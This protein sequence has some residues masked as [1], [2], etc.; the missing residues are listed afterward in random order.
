VSE[1]DRNRGAELRAEQIRWKGRSR[2]MSRASL[3]MGERLRKMNAQASTLD[4]RLSR[5]A[6]EGMRWHMTWHEPSRP[7]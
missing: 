1:G 3:S 2:S 6:E 5:H 4:K 7:G